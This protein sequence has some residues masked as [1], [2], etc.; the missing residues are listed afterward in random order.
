[1]LCE[2]SASIDCAREIRGI[3]SIANAVA[4][5][6][7]SA[8]VVCGLVSG[9]RKPIRIEPE[10]S[11]RIASGS[12]G[13]IVTTTSLLPHLRGVARDLRPGRGERRVGQQR[14]RAGAGLHDDVQALRL[15]LADDLRHE[16]NTVLSRRGLLRDTDPHTRGENVSDR[17]QRASATAAIS[18]RLGRI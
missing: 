4:F 7:A 2:D 16:R 12:G 15:Q 11:P 10:P 17:T 6:S 3:A 5:A 9:A 14:V 18:S 8:R 1:M 13:A